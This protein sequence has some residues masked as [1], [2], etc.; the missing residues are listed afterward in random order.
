[1][2][3]TMQHF[4]SLS[5]KILALPSVDL[6]VRILKVF[7]AVAGTKDGITVFAQMR[8]AL[9]T[10]DI[11]LQTLENLEIAL[12]NPPELRAL[13]LSAVWRIL[14]V[15]DEKQEIDLSKIFLTAPEASEEVLPSGDFQEIFPEA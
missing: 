3:V 12:R 5:P 1:M 6:R 15:E 7:Q 8:K 4:R 9:K 13:A 10:P 2:V 11:F 14:A